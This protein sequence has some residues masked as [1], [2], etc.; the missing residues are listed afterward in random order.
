MAA[1]TARPRPEQHCLTSPQIHE[2]ALNNII[3][4]SEF[5]GKVLNNDEMAESLNRV[6]QTS[7]IV[8]D[9]KKRSKAEFEFAPFDPIRIDFEESRIQISVNLKSFRI[10]NGKRWQNLNLKVLY[11]PTIEDGFRVKMSQSDEGLRIKGK[12]LNVGDQLAIGVICEVLFPKQFEVALMPARLGQQLSVSNLQA[13]QFVVSNGW[14]G[15]S[16]GDAPQTATSH[17]QYQQGR[18]LPNRNRR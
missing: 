17:R 5:A 18:S 3:N 16:V 4:R 8:D 6:F 11:D 9:G 10:G 14:L 2:S 12:R 13:T 7:F 1:N 15:I